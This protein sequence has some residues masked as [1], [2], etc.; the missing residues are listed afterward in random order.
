MPRDGRHVNRHY[1][2]FNIL[3]NIVGQGLAPAVK[4]IKYDLL[5]P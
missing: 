4:S 2:V 1:D 5:Y 3:S